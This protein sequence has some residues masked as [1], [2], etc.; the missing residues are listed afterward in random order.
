MEEC[1]MDIRITEKA[2]A[3]LD[4]INAGNLRIAVQGYG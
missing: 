4:N 2:A 3:E 1:N